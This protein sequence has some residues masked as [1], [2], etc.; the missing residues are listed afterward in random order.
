MRRRL[1][2]ATALGL[3]STAALAAGACRRA[4]TAPDHLLI[5][6]PRVTCVTGPKVVCAGDCD[7]QIPSRLDEL[8]AA[9]GATFGMRHGCLLDAAGRVSCW[10]DATQGQLGHAPLRGR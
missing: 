10:G 8:A 9:Q 4:S 5:L 2:T 6:G 7:F 3:V 1:R